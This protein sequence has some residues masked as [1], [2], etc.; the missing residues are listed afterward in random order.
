MYAFNILIF[1]IIGEVI[2]GFQ[3]Y[4]AGITS[5]QNLHLRHVHR[6][7]TPLRKF[8]SLHATDDTEDEKARRL[9]ER[10]AEY[11]KKLLDS[12]MQVTKNQQ[13]FFTIGKFL[14]PI[15]VIIWGYTFYTGTMQN[16]PN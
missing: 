14:F 5:I 12:A 1:L 7:Y 2:H 3:N 6:G 11:E 13:S 9:A 15:I 4:K 16:P 8:T 10:K